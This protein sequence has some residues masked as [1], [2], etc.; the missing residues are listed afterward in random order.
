MADKQ[1]YGDVQYADPGYQA[2]GKKRYPID[3]EEHCRAAWSYINQS[4]NAAKYSADDLAKI[5]K[6]IM[7]AGKK[8]GMEFGSGAS[9]LLVAAP[10]A[11]SWY[12]ISN[13]ASGDVEMAIY[14]DIGGMGITAQQMLGDL[15]SIGDRNLTLRMNTQGGDVFDGIAIYEALKRRRSPVTCVVDSLAASIGSVIA[16]A[17]DKV[18]MARP[19]KMMIHDAHGATSGNAAEVGKFVDLLDRTSDTIAGI[20][21]DHTGGDAAFWRDLMRNETWFTAEEAVDAGLADEVQADTARPAAHAGVD[22]TDTACGSDPVWDPELFREA[23][24]EAAHND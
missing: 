21:A 23:I 15:E 16:M 4:K 10:T 2:D 5:K 7:T 6:R 11:K 13:L 20:Y 12:Q 24:K 3:T 8:F 18:V 19:A 1:P 9:N 14:N 17:A 22:V